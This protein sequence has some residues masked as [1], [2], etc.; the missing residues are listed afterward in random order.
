MQKH[1]Y[2]TDDSMNDLQLKY[3]I[4]SQNRAVLFDLVEFISVFFNSCWSSRFPALTDRLCPYQE[5]SS[6]L[7]VI[8]NA[9]NKPP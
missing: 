9:F 2:E 6:K 1:G 4:E 7:K 5:R 8:K 3:L